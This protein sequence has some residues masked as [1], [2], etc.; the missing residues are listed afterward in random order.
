MISNAIF[1]ANK[2]FILPLSLSLSLSLSCSLF[3]M[4][5][6]RFLFW[7]HFFLCLL[8]C[9]FICFE[10]FVGLFV[11]DRIFVGSSFRAAVCSF[12]LSL[13]FFVPI[14]FYRESSTPFPL[15]PPSPPTS[16]SRSKDFSGR[17][18]DAGESRTPP[19]GLHQMVSGNLRPLQPPQPRASFINSP[20]SPFQL[21]Q[22]QCCTEFKQLRNCIKQRVIQ[23]D[24]PAKRQKPLKQ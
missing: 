21:G 9:W 17:R 1:L 2:P 5:F 14:L 8:V 20:S 15:P 4:F 10:L 13:L 19:G 22:Q 12:F 7:I 3:S 23:T 24:S 16:C 6:F 18:A 11:L